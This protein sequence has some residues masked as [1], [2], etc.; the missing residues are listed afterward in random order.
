MPALDVV[1]E[2]YEP[3]LGPALAGEIARDVAAVA[4]EL[5]AVSDAQLQA[6]VADGE[7]AWRKLDRSAAREAAALAGER[8]RVV[9]V[10]G[11]R[12]SLDTRV[13]QSALRLACRR[14]A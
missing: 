12:A 5:H 9:A 3:V 11:G 8:D 10:L 6:L 1:L 7:A 4:G 2:R 14:R 13:G